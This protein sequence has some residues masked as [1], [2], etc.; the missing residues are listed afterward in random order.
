MLQQQVTVKLTRPG[1]YEFTGASGI[2]GDGDII[3]QTQPGIEVGARVQVTLTLPA[4][5]S[6]RIPLQIR[7]IVLQFK[8]SFTAGAFD[9]LVIAP[10][11]YT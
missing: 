10:E 11:S 2:K 6:Q 7:G 9:S 1:H 3:L 8:K 4:K 5:T